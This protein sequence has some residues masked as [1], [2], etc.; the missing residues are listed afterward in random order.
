M[1]I[2]QAFNEIAVAQGGTASKSGTIAGAIDALNDALAGSDQPAEQTIEAAVRLLGEHISQGGGGGSCVGT[3]GRVFTGTTDASV[4]DAAYP[5]TP[6]Y[7][8][9]MA[10]GDNTALRCYYSLDDMSRSYIY[11]VAS[12]LSVSTEVIPGADGF[13]YHETLYKCTLNGD[14]NDGYTYKTITLLDPPAKK[15]A[16]N[17]YQDVY[18]EFTMP[19]LQDGEY[20]AIAY[21]YPD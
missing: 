16:Q 13:N 10:L 5:N 21:D 1:T 9:Q 2:A 15:I 18:F 12:G 20:L 3:L 11:A 17:E 8:T 4:G 7:V 6:M 14:E 19:E